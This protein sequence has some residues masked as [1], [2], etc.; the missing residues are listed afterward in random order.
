MKKLQAIVFAVVLAGLAGLIS[1]GGS[2]D[3]TPKEKAIQ[4]LTSKTS[5]TV[6]S[7]VVPAQTATIADDWSAFTVSFTN[8]TM[9]TSGYPTGAEAVWPSG[10]YS[11]SEDGMTITSSAAPSGWVLNIATLTETS[12]NSTISVPD[13]VEIGRVDAL[14]GDYT[15]NLR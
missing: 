2:D 6:N 12:F 8:T 1:C 5:W 14:D 11:V 9:S 7:V 15:F 4:M 10:S 13:G 3:P